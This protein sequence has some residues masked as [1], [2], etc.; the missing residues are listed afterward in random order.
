MDHGA[1]RSGTGPGEWAL[2]AG[3]ASGPEMWGGIPFPGRMAGHAPARG[4]GAALS[5]E[6]ATPG[7]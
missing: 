6:G 1:M 5:R 4:S 2:P 3:R 7:E